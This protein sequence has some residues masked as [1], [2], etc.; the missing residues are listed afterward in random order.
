MKINKTNDN[1]KKSSRS[2]EGVRP[3]VSPWRCPESVG[4]MRAGEVEA[5]SRP[6]AWTRAQ[7]HWTEQWGCPGMR[8]LVS[9]RGASRCWRASRGAGHGGRS[10]GTDLDARE[11][12]KSQMIWGEEEGV[13]FFSQ[14]WYAL[15]L[16][17]LLHFSN[18]S[19]CPFCLPSWIL[20]AS[21]LTYSFSM[22]AC[23]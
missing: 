6:S 10:P 11:T 19:W 21:P 22:P 18:T 17:F 2:R 15:S 23:F 14:N 16:S 12:G 13:L 5:L 4:W 7:S 1:N 8:H 3:R 20:P 9:G